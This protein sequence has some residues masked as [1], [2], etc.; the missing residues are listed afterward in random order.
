MRLP[1][2][3]LRPVDRVHILDLKAISLCSGRRSGVHRLHNWDNS[4]PDSDR[5]AGLMVL[6]MRIR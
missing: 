3:V 4:L 2:S 5:R 6:S 1:P